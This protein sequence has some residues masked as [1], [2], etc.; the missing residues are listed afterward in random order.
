MD[1]IPLW[2]MYISQCNG[3]DSDLPNFS[4]PKVLIQKSNG[5]NREKN[6]YPTLISKVILLLLQFINP[7]M[8][9]S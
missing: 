9:L 6:W 4:T 1:Q 8:E 5:D 3:F 7:D 2:L